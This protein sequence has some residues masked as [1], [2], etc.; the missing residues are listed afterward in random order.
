MEVKLSHNDA[1]SQWY[2]T[3]NITK[4]S[5]ETCVQLWE[6]AASFKSYGNLL[7]NTFSITI[8]PMDFEQIFFLNLG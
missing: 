7:S 5:I 3:E 6:F 4:I 1:L 2:M 8:S